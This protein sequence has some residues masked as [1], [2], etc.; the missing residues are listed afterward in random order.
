M[1]VSHGKPYAGNPHVRFDEGAD[2]PDEGR[3]ALLH[4]FNRRRR[5][6][7]NG[8][9]CRPEVVGDEFILRGFSRNHSAGYRHKIWI[10]LI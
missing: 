5:S 9:V 8:L 3:S 6:A 4:Q 1:T 10:S 7:V 2:V